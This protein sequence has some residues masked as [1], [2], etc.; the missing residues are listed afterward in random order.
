MLRRLGFTSASTSDELCFKCY[1]HYQ[2]LAN[3]KAGSASYGENPGTSQED[4]AFVPSE[5]LVQAVN[6]S[7]SALEVDITPLKVPR[8]IRAER[9]KT[10]GNSIR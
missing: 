3:A 4:A 2:T 7:L 6:E 8:A 1:K 9:R 10:Y 5:E